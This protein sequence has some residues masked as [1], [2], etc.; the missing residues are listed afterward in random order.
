LFALQA[1][2]AEKIV[3]E[4]RAKLTPREKTE[5]ETQPTKD[6]VAFS[7]YERAK[8]LIYDAVANAQGDKQ[9]FQ[10]VRLLEQA[11]LRDPQFALAYYQLA[12]A[13]DQL[14]LVGADHTPQRVAFAQAAIDTLHRLR[15][16]S[17]EAHLA[18][19]KHLYWVFRDYQHA[20]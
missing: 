17:G 14:H 5:I 2:V 7:L 16:D 18:S 19:A 20:R 15:P 10:A 13:H 9:L 6:L 11:I 12:H 1:D 3:G 4:L 8:E